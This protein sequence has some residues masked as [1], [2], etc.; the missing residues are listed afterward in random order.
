MSASRPLARIGLG[1][2]ALV[3]SLA[4]FAGHAPRLAAAEEVVLATVDG[5]KIT[6]TDLLLYMESLPPEYRHRLPPEVLLP[7]ITDQLINMKLIAAKGRESGL[8]D[9]E[10]YTDHLEFYKLRLLQQY[11]ISDRLEELVTDDDVRARYETF[12]EEFPQTEEI[13]ARHI[14]VASEDEAKAVVKELEEGADFAELAKTRSTGP[15]SKRGG[16]LGYFQHDQMVPEFAD[17]AFALSVGEIS[18]PVQTQFGWHVIKVEDRRPVTPPTYEEAEPQLRAE[19]S[20][21]AVSKLIEEA[22]GAATIERFEVD[23]ATLLGGD[24]ANSGSAE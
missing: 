15:S 14:L 6:R 7:A 1:A 8:E 22:R 17:A 23:P 10:R 18:A 11:Y 24:D 13:R 16:D 12:K 2:V 21:D 19:L 9:D 4:V 5:Q 20:N 3:F